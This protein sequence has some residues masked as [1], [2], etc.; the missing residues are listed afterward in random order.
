MQILTSSKTGRTP[1]FL[2]RLVEAFPGGVAYLDSNL[3]FAFCNDVQASYFGRGA[4][5]V[6]G[7]RLRDVTP[8]NPDFW[9]EIERVAET[10]V[11]SPQTALSVTWRNRPEEGEHHY[12]VSYIADLGRRGRV[13]GVFM[14]A[15]EVTQSILGESETEKSLRDRNRALEEIVRERDVLIGIV[16][17]EL[18]TPLTTIFGNAHL[19]LRRL[20]D[21]DE[22]SRTR[23]INDI[24]LEAER[25]NRLV[26]NMLLL[27]RAGAQAPVPTEPVS[28]DKAIEEAVEEH[29][30][31]FSSR[32][33]QVSV[34]PIA[35]L[36]EAQ[37]EYLKQVLQNLLGNAEKYS[38]ADQRIDVRARRSGTGVTVSMLDHG[39]GIDPA[40]AEIIFQPFYRS[41]RT[42][43]MVGGTGI[44]LAV[45]KLLVQ[46]QSGRIS[47]RPRRGG[48]AVFEFTL[49]AAA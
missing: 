7:Q 41:A 40:E 24:R 2:R 19:L 22:D 44:G 42:A 28:V 30:Q 45:C 15:L 46:A 34:K 10:V 6:I 21:L 5:E 3:V 20:E 49:P 43:T 39:P 14:T 31:Q 25:L 13:R 17:H 33:V 35:L 12:L 27:A 29:R 18:R 16:S 36:A 4:E 9:R 38:P 47:T 32:P 26:E 8:E 23:A 11:R 37:P 1:A 48:G